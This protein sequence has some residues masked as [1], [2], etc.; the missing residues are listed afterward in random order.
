VP[1]INGIRRLARIEPIMAAHKLE[2]YV[3]QAVAG[4][5]SFPRFAA[6]LRSAHGPAQS[7]ET[8]V[9]VTPR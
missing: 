3:R 7:R 6:A 2:A 9:S 8:V 5:A 1:L 4:E